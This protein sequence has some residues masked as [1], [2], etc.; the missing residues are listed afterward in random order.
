MSKLALLSVFLLNFTENYFENVVLMKSAIKLQRGQFSKFFQ[1]KV[2]DRGKNFSEINPSS[3]FPFLFL[4]WRY[5]RFNVHIL[6]Q[7]PVNMGEAAIIHF[8]I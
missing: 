8:L 1:L 4:S 7:R 3:H 6:E 5:K 2:T